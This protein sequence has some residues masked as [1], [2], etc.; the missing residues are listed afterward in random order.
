[1]P[2]AI[3]SFLV[4]TISLNLAVWGFGYAEVY[5]YQDADG[6]WVFTDSPPPKAEGLQK[7]DGMIAGAHGLTDLAASLQAAYPPENHIVRASLAAV[8]ITSSLGT[9]SG[10]FISENGHIITNRHVLMGDAQQQETITERF[11]FLDEQ[12]SQA[13]QRVEM[14]ENRLASAQADLEQ[15][16]RYLDRLPPGTVRRNEMER[17]Y[18]RDLD[19][20]RA[21][22]KNHRQTKKQYA[23][24]K[25]TYA[26]KKSE[27][28]SQIATA[29]IS[30]SFT[31]T[32]KDGT[33]LH[34]FL[35]R[36]SPTHD[37]ALLK[38]TGYRTPY[39]QPAAK[40]DISQGR[41]VYAIGNPLNLG[42]SVSRGIISGFRD[43]FLQTDARI[44]PG[45]SGGPL[46]TAD[47]RVAG[48]N[49]MK[50]LTRGFEGL[51]FAIP[52]QTVLNEFGDEL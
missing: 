13:D 50:E 24:Q 27:Y 7:M 40:G 45:N 2:N 5:Q 4:T 11:E 6:S 16:K 17:R 15:M 23:S 20:V 14:E 31:V 12:I 37:L 49:T 22:E 38:V 8:S 46:I 29:G 47:G 10:F 48:I 52:I 18:Q 19:Y 34:A 41:E 42:D 28:R 30:R 39:L 35:V 33:E 1:M 9:G 51:G 3:I 32:L 25:E 43:G 21:W 44:Y 26:A 36:T